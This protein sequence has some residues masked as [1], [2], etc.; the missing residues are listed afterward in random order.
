[1]SFN[2]PYIISVV[3]CAMLVI[4]VGV[5]F[6]TLIPKDSSQNTKLLAIITVF[7]F[8]ASLI[9][10][11]LALYHFSHNPANMIQFILG[12]VMIIILPCALIAASVSTVTISNLRD[13]L[14]AG[15][16]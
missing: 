5:T 11:A 13:T 2:A 12:I 4:V 8:V 14:A 9:A 16:Q 10:Y 7:S 3:I 15:T 1:M 6:G